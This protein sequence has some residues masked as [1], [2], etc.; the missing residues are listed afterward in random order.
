MFKITAEEKQWII[1]RRLK[2]TARLK[3]LKFVRD[4][5]SGKLHFNG[6]SSVLGFGRS[7]NLYLFQEDEY[8]YVLA[9]NTGLPYVGLYELHSNGTVINEIF[10]QEGMSYEILGDNWE[11][12]SPR[13]IVK[14][15][16]PYLQPYLG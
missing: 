11:S 3:S 7:D 12:K 16:Q 1:N 15:L 2:I 10:Y 9:I 8:Y 6:V 4:D 14:Q 13:T 5:K